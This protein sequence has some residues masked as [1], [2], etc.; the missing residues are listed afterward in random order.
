MDKLAEKSRHVL[1]YEEIKG[2]LAEQCTSN[3]GQRLAHLLLPVT[4]VE[5]A[6]VLLDQTGTA[7]SVM[8]TLGGFPLGGFADLGEIFQRLRLGAQ[9]SLS[10]LVNVLDVAVVAGRLRKFFDDHGPYDEFR[11][12]SEGIFKFPVI[13]KEFNLA[14]DEH[15]RIADSASVKLSDVRRKLRAAEQGVQEKLASIVTSGEHSKYLQESLVTIREGRYVV[16]V[17]AEYKNI[18]RGI[19]HDQSASGLTVYIEPMA[20]VDLNNKIRQ[21]QLEERDEIE[22]I[23]AYLSGIAHEFREDLMLSHANIAAVDVI[24]GKARLAIKMRAVHPSLVNDGSFIINQGRHP[25]LGDNAVPVSIKLVP[26][27]QA[28]IITGPNTGGKTVTLKMVGLLSLMAASGFFVPATDGTQITIFKNIFADIGDEQ[29]IEQSLSTFSSHM[30]T[31]VQSTELADANTLVLLDELG[32]GTDPTEGAALAMAIVDHLLHRQARIVATTHFSELKVYAYTNPLV[33]NA[34]MEFDV[35]SLRPTYRLLMGLPGKSN[36]FEISARL[37]LAGGIIERAKARLTHENIKVEDLIRG[38]EES[39]KKVALKEAQIEITLKEAAG[40]LEEAKASFMQ[41]K[42]DEEGVRQRGDEKLRVLLAEAEEQVNQILEAARQQAQ[43][44]NA[45]EAEQLKHEVRKKL[46]ESRGKLAKEPAAE[47]QKTQE[48]AVGDAVELIGLDKRG[49]IKEIK[50]PDVIVQV[51]GMRVSVKKD[52]LLPDT[53]V[54][55]SAQGARRLAKS[56]GM[57]KAR[58][59]NIELDLRGMMVDEALDATEKYIDDA[60]LAGLSL[61]Y[62]I[63]GKGTGALRSAIREMLKKHAMVSSFA[64]GAFNE[65]GDGV[66]VARLKI[67]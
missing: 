3:A 60:Y 10:E 19:I 57:D 13:E 2:L 38:L 23:L 37:G 66:T 56:L 21:L 49:V 47:R 33:D 30:K 46:R 15:G 45:R 35:Q 50:G 44:Y 8:A 20:V 52:S 63:H 11:E 61:I 7:L 32:A 16:P 64:P 65:G 39:Q 9:L 51:G 27:S 53:S 34:S 24:Q 26:G 4:D 14:I 59:I 25:L 5:A 42:R 67:N 43:D 41:L 17:R 6:E 12:I 36:A 31:I 58:S 18:V 62:I 48:L 55:G 1:Q 22:R 54:A 40:K 28:L 29:S